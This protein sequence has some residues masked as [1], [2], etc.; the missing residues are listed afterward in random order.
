MRMN[1]EI[2]IK[3]GERYDVSWLSHNHRILFLK[4]ES[5]MTVK[6]GLRL[7]VRAN[8]ENYGGKAEILTAGQAV[9]RYP[10][11]FTGKDVKIPKEDVKILLRLRPKEYLFC[12]G[13]QTTMTNF[14]RSLIKKEMGVR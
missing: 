13:Q 5:V 11:L 4:K 8:Q 12:T 14:I 10:E 6:S 7:A 9:R 3:D 1:K 2:K